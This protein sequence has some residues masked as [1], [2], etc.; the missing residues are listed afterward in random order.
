[1]NLERR[2]V[3]E[4]NQVL[5][6]EE[7]YWFQKSRENKIRL[8]DRNTRYFHTST[9][10]RRRR[11]EIMALKQ[12]DGSWCNEPDQLKHMAVEYFQKL[13]AADGVARGQEVVLP[14]YA[15]LSE[16][17]R[18]WLMQPVTK[19]E[20]RRAVCSMGAFKAPGPDGIQPFFFQRF[21]HVVGDSVKYFVQC[22]IRNGSIPDCVNQSLITL[23]PKVEHPEEIS[24]FRPISLCNVIVRIVSKVLVG[25][26]F[27]SSWVSLVMSSVASS[28]LAILWNGERTEFFSPSRG[29]RQ[30][31]PL[32]PYLFVFCMEVRGRKI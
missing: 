2:L 17:D 18:E 24:Q 30:G 31:D 28:Q 20:V 21:W 26:Q 5:F 11:N 6:Q 32:L 8:G 9:L 13:Y 14:S 7:I 25:M 19:E 3:Q 4:Y 16:A 22:G 12:T 27:P 15:V 10:I 1:M 23:I 29:L